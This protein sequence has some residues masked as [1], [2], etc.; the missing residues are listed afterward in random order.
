MSK[1]I[2]TIPGI[3]S[4]LPE[5]QLSEASALKIVKII[6]A[7]AIATA[8]SKVDPEAQVRFVKD[9]IRNQ[10]FAYYDAEMIASILA[11]QLRIR[12]GSE[13]AANA[14]LDAQIKLHE[15]VRS[16]SGLPKTACSVVNRAG[17]ESQVAVL[18]DAL[19]WGETKLIIEDLLGIDIFPL[20]EPI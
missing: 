16:K 15:I 20:L 9:E 4:A 12:L 18:V 19:F 8:V 10:V 7:D 14:M 1:Y 5:L 13:M 2:L 6:N 17:F 3:I 11:L